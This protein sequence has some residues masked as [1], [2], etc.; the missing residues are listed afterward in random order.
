MDAS[1]GSILDVVRGDAS[2]SNNTLVIFISDN[3]AWIG[4]NT[5]LE[6]PYLNQHSGIG[7]FDGGSNGPLR[8]G[9]GSTWE[10]GVRVPCLV[11]WPGI[12]PPG[13]TSMAPISAL[14]F[15]PTFVNIAMGYRGGIKQNF[16]ET[17]SATEILDGHDVSTIWA[18]PQD[19]ENDFGP[20]YDDFM[21]FWREKEVYAVRSKRYKVHWITRSGF[22]TSDEGSRQIPPIVYDIESDPSEAYPLTTDIYPDLPKLLVDCEMALKKHLEDIGQLPAPQYGPQNWT[23]VPCCPRGEFDPSAAI[24]AARAGDWGLALWDGCVCERE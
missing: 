2:L 20:W 3:G 12:T 9:K 14:D 23:L 8:G 18:H 21:W 10:G 16:Q 22:N 1:I 11:W 13:S 19:K 15:Y 4:A 7:P 5:G 6:N 17:S 24:A